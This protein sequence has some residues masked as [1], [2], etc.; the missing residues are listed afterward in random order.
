[1]HVMKPKIILSMVAG[2]FVSVGTAVAQP[3]LAVDFQPTT[4]VAAD[5]FTVW[6][7]GSGT[8]ASATPQ[9]RTFGD[10]AVNLAPVGA[11]T[12]G[13]RTRATPVNMAGFAQSAVFRDF[14]FGNIAGD[15]QGLA[16]TITGLTPAAEYHFKCYSYDSGSG[17]GN[18]VSNWSANG[19]PVVYRYTFFG[20]ASLPVL[21]DQ[22]SFRFNA[23]ADG[24][25]QIVIQGLPAETTLMTPASPAVF[26][27]GFEMYLGAQT[28]QPPR[29]IFWTE[30]GGFEES[31]GSVWSAGLNGVGRTA[32]ATGLTRP[33]GIALDPAKRHVYWA[34]DGFGSQPSRIVRANFDGTGQ[35]VLFSGLED[36]FVN[37]QMLAL[38]LKNGHIYWTAHFTGVMRG[39]LDGT[40]APVN[41]GGSAGKYTPL[42]LD[43]INGHIYYGDPELGILYRM[44]LDGQN[45][46]EL[47]SDI[48][49][50]QQPYTFNSISLDVANGHIYYAALVAN[51][52][53]RMN[54]DGSNQITLL[55]DA[56]L[57]PHGVIVVGDALYWVG[58]NGKR[59]GTS[60]LDGTSNI[61]LRL[62]SLASSFAF[63]VAAVT[64]F[65]ING[66]TIEGSDTVINWQGGFGPYQLQGR[67]GV[68]QGVW[69]NIGTPTEATRATN[70]L[71]G[72]A[73]FYRVQGN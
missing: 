60:N 30:T 72:D 45:S 69:Q 9:S 22:Y 12:L 27:N 36:G 67:A 29:E 14:V 61:N 21:D 18:R 2:L 34:D 51:Q 46:V 38:D 65:K 4:G 31:Q 43:L 17:T 54:L 58:G 63:G 8:G 68:G 32:I 19:V 10:Y 41:L 73:M 7:G 44:D 6:D 37:A 26:L 13:F 11:G 35:E 66:L 71:S 56:G 33:I 40:G 49:A 20:A 57:L 55:T 24:T 39:N 48:T 64:P 28:P 59:M 15:Q 16:L 1:M 70:S 5:G 3:V 25:G 62:A 52:I 53:K 50:G 23:T 42:D 47:A